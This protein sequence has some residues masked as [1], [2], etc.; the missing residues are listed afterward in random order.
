MNTPRLWTPVI[1]PVTWAVHFV[2]V[3]SVAAVWC[4]RPMLV[5]ATVL[6]LIITGLCLHHG[7]TLIRFDWPDR[8]HDRDTAEG[9][10]RF[11]GYTTVL[12]AG[13]SF[14]ATVYSAIAIAM[15]DCP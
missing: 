3:T 9:R 11:I 4:G 10:R 7:A 5:V 13:M 2:F 12:L 1:A 15:V 6:A 8:P 14:F